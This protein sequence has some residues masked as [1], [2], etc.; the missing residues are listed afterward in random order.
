M[1]ATLPSGCADASTTTPS[2]SLCFE[3]VDQRTE[4]AALQCVG[5][6]R[7]QANALHLTARRALRPARRPQTSCAPLRVRGAGASVR[8]PGRRLGAER[9]RGAAAPGAGASCAAIGGDG[10][11]LAEG[12]ERAEAADGLKAADAGGDRPSLTILSRPIS[13]V[14]RGVRAAAQL[15]REAVAS[16]TTLPCHRTFRRRAPWRGTRLRPRRW[17]RPQ[18]SRLWHWPA[19]RREPPPSATTRTSALRLLPARRHSESHFLRAI[20]APNLAT[21]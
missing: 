14:A 2:P 17:A 9:I 19:P 10:K 3:V 18:W 12:I 20:P 8:L 15:G 1:R 16:L 11:I 4:L 7:H 21:L 13:P 5:A 6:Q